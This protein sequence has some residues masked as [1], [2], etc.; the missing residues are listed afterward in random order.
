[1]LLYYDID[2]FCNVLAR[3]LPVSDET[4]DYARFCAAYLEASCKII[5]L[6]YQIKF[7]SIDTLDLDLPEANPDLGHGYP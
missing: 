5:P 1:M 2:D 6:L 4:L 3:V 7:T